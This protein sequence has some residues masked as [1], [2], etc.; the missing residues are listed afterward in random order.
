MFSCMPGAQQAFSEHLLKE[1]HEWIRDF[2]MCLLGKYGYLV[3]LT[4]PVLHINL[5]ICAK[6]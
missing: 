2:K 4:A 3:S 5:Y 6:I 1:W